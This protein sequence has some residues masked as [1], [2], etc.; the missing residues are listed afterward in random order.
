MGKKRA[1]EFSKVHGDILYST[2]DELCSRELGPADYLAVAGEFNAVLI[3]NIP[4]LTLEI[5]DQ[6]RRFVT[7]ID[8]LYEKKVKLICTLRQ[9]FEYVDF[10]DKDFDFKRTLSRLVEMRSEKYFQGD[11]LPT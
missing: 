3:A 7:L 2:F 11:S 6:V 8:S 4:V 9:P 10:K 5:R 1:L